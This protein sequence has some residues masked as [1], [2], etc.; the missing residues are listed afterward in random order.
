MRLSL[1]RKKPSSHWALGFF[2]FVYLLSTSRFSA[3]SLLQYS[4]RSL[5]DGLVCRPALPPPAPQHQSSSNSNAKSSTA[6]S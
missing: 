5:P 4:R 1:T 3:A 6:F 2:L